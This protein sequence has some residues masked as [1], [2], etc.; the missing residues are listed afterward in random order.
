MRRGFPTVISPIS[1]V[2]VAAAAAKPG[3][4]AA[5]RTYDTNTGDES[6]R[7]L[8][9]HKQSVWSLLWLCVR[10]LGMRVAADE[11]AGNVNLLRDGCRRGSIRR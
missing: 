6:D 8:P 3:R 7:T 10:R 4:A 11:E 1:P 5:F 2:V 9:S